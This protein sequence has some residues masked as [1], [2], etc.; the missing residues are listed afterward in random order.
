MSTTFIRREDVVRQWH[1]LDA[2]GQRLGRLASRIARLLMGKDKPSFSPFVDTG[3]HVVIINAA[4]VAVTGK[5]ETDKVY[6]HH[7]GY[8]GGLK[9]ARVE[10]V[11]KKHPVRLVEQAVKGMLP[12]SRLGRA[13]FRKM[14]VYVGS[15]HPHQAQQPKRLELASARLS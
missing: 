1:L 4:K 6:H 15:D 12:K 11:R 5:K 7:T 13:Q 2:D 9:S 14:K 3:D 10:E 8:L